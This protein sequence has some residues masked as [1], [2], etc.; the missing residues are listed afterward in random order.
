MDAI[1]AYFDNFKNIIDKVVKTQS[2]ALHQG[3]DN[4]RC[5]S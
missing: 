5:R 4:K 3:Q 2:E 1:A